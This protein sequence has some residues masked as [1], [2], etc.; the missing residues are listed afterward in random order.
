MT[1]DLAKV[2]VLLRRADS[3]RAVLLAFATLAQRLFA[4]VLAMVLLERRVGDKVVATLAFGALFTVRTVLEGSAMARTEADLFERVAESVLRGDVLRPSVLPDQ[5]LHLEAW[6]GIYHVAQLF[7]RTLPNLLGDSLASLLLAVVVTVVAPPRLVGWA[8]LALVLAAGALLVSRRFVGRAVDRGLKLQ[9]RVL[10]S[11]VDALEGRLELVSSGDTAGYLADLGARARAWGNS[12]K[13][14]ALSTAL[15]GRLAFVGV[16]GLVILGALSSG[17]SLGSMGMSLPDAA[18]LASVSPA[19]VGLAQGMHG[20][21]R[22]RRWVDLLVRILGEG[23]ISEGSGQRRPS[24]PASVAFERVSFRYPAEDEGLHALSE[25]TFTWDGSDV[26]ALAGPNGSGKS[27]CLRLLLGLAA[28]T[29]GSVRVGDVALEDV[30]LDAWRSRIAFL[31]QRPYLPLRASVR[32]ALDW[33]PSGVSDERMVRALERVRLLHVLG[34]KSGAPLDARV[35][36]LSVGERQRV[37]LARLLCRDAALFLL[38]EPDANLDRA[39]IA[40]VAEVIRELA[41][42]G[43]VAFVAHTPE[44]L[45]AADRVIILQDGRQVE[46]AQA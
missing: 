9:E 38:D 41:A 27:T 24:L 2:R 20:F 6:Q 12:G 10:E 39:G 33:P 16:A 36:A 11:F 14:L 28:P 46:A 34:R 18:L 31:P 7:S 19:F 42:R 21:V 26:L 8:A 4:P 1:A 5:D 23:R 22:E 30:E 15:A 29:H 35:D 3:R 43:M 17:W 44:L 13:Y 40:L 45:A 37:G 32:R 25:V